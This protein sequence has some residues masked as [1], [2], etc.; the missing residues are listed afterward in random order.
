MR[1]FILKLE[2]EEHISL[3]W[4]FSDQF[5]YFSLKMSLTFLNMSFFRKFR[6]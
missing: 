4:E 1:I 3:N 6:T 5:K 2:I